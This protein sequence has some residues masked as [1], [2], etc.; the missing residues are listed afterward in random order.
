[1]KVTNRAITEQA[2]SLKD[3]GVEILQPGESKTLV[4]ADPDSPENRGRRHAGTV[5]FGKSEPEEPAAPKSGGK[6]D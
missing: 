3:G 5:T 4:L 6:K 2:F 1:M